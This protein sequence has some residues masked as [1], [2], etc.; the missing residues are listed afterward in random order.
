MFTPGKPFQPSL[1]HTLAYYRN[2]Y[3]TAVIGFMIQVLGLFVCDKFHQFNFADTCLFHKNLPLAN[4]LAYLLQVTKPNV[5]FYCHQSSGQEVLG[6]QGRW[7]EQVDT[8]VDVIK[9]FYSA[10]M[11]RQSRLEGLY[12]A[13]FWSL[14]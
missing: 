10:Q 4:T 9:L 1:A 11:K 13:S 6:G 12:L 8:K 3:I 14:F 5:L 2:P 7:V